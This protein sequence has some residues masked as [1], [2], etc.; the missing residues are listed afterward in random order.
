MFS[1]DSLRKKEK[2]QTVLAH[3]FN[4]QHTSLF[5]ACGEWLEETIALISAYGLTMSILRFH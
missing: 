4:N 2:D 1:C 5:E 3:H